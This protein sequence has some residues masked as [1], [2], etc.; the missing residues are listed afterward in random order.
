MI[1]IRNLTSAKRHKRRYDAV[2]TIEDPFCP[3]RLR[4]HRKPHPPH[5]VLRFEDLD[6]P[7]PLLA[8]PEPHHVEAAIEFARK[9]RYGSLL[10]HCH[11]GVCR[12]TAVGLAV[13]ADR[14][15]PGRER[16]AVEELL[17][18]APG[19]HP[20][21]SM[22]P[23]IDETLGRGGAVEAAWMEREN[24]SASYAEYRGMKARI[25]E[26]RRDLF[27]SRPQDGYYPAVTF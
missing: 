5:L 6:H 9:H 7:E 27:R 17:R 20:T 14:M 11:A 19:A 15:G 8:T 21:L 10:I 3:R 23:M 24:S 18:I 12:S 25:L 16:E 13:L 2:I 22:L 26:E 1:E 4:F